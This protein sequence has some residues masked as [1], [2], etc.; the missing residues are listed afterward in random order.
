MHNIERQNT[1]SSNIT[2]LYIWYKQRKYNLLFGISQIHTFPTAREGSIINL[3]GGKEGD[4]RLEG[5]LALL[6]RQPDSFRINP[7][8]S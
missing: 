3:E 8:H 6:L 5:I 1:S 2:W 4:G 7:L